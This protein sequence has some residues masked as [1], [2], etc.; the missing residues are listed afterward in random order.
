MAAG[1][2]VGVLLPLSLYHY[3]IA[4]TNVEHAG[5]RDYLNDGPVAALRAI[6]PNDARR[7]GV[8]ASDDGGDSFVPSNV[9]FSARLITSF[10]GEAQ[11]PATVYVGV[12]N[13]KDSG[14][15]FVSRTGGLS[16]CSAA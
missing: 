2:G 1:A 9:G 7:R 3:L 16:G 8:L 10:V 5:V 4:G 13:D 14:G 6:T 12:V 11:H 15:V